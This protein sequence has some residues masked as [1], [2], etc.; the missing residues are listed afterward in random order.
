MKMQNS[1]N[2][3]MGHFLSTK[4]LVLVILNIQFLLMAVNLITNNSQ[5]FSCQQKQKDENNFNRNQN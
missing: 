2:C 1:E 3:K 5:K 4:C